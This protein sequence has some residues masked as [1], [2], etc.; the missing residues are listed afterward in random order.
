MILQHPEKLIFGITFV[1]LDPDQHRI[2][3]FCEL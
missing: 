3:V 2:R 1:A